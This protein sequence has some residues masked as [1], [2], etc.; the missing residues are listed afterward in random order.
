[1]RRR[2]AHD[3]RYG[4]GLQR[5]FRTKSITKMHGCKIISTRGDRHGK[6]I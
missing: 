1:M 2:T 4:K 6:I 3:G 5:S